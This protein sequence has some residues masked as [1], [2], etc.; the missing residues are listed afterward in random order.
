[1]QK[2]RAL[3]AAFNLPPA[4]ALF[5]AFFF[6]GDIAISDP[7][8]PPVSETGAGASSCD[9]QNVVEYPSDQTSESNAACESDAEITPSDRNYL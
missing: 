2:C 7:L 1:M 3:M 4:L 6:T 5:G 9:P 8:H